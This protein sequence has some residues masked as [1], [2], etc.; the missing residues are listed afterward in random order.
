[1]GTYVCML[2]MILDIPDTFKLCIL[3]AWQV[4]L[5]FLFPDLDLLLCK[6]LQEVLK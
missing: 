4:Y 3:F 6:Q 5:L 2:N 1:M